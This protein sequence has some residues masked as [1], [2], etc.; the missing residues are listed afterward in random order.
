MGIKQLRPIRYARTV[1]CVSVFLRFLHMKAR[2][3]GLCKL[4][5][6]LNQGLV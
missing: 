4:R 2:P 3:M 1:C 5:N 6:R